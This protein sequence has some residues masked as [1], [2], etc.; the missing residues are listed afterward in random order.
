MGQ[1]ETYIDPTTTNQLLN[2][3]SLAIDETKLVLRLNELN[4]LAYSLKS[5]DKPTDRSEYLRKEITM[6]EVQLNY[7]REK[8]Y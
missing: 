5:S 6:L 1:L 2:N 7:I 3:L 4:N 8:A